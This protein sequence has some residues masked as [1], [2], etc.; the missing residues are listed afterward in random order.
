MN[1]PRER[2]IFERVLESF[3]TKEAAEERV[4][5]TVRQISDGIAI[6]MQNASPPT[7]APSA[8]APRQLAPM[9]LTLAP[10]GRYL[11]HLSLR[12]P[13][14]LSQPLFLSIS[15]FSLLSVLTNN[16]TPYDLS[17]WV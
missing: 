6:A 3:K 14:F 4:F 13:L 17:D 9:P 11:E 10:A 7:P 1:A 2:F 15:L 16:V 12:L 8:P 5:G